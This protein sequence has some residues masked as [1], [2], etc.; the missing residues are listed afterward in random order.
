M[1]KFKAIL[2]LLLVAALFCML[3]AACGTSESNSGDSSSA[4]TST[5]SNTPANNDDEDDQDADAGDGE[6]VNIVVAYLDVSGND[7]EE[8]DRLT[9]Y[10]NSI[11]EP[12]IGVHVSIYN[13]QM[14]DYGTQVPLMIAGNEQLDVVNVSPMGGTKLSGLLSNNSLLDVREELETYAAEAIAICGDTADVYRVGDAMYGLPTYRVNASNEYIILRKDILEA[15]DTLDMANNISTWSDV[16]ELFAA[17]YD[18]CT[19]NNVYVIGGQKSCINVQAFWH[20]DSLDDYTN[21]ENLGESANMITVGEDGKVY[22]RW[23]DPDLVN[24]MKRAVNWNNNGW[25][26]PDTVLG[27]DHT[28]NLYKQGVIFSYFNHTEIGVEVA[29]KLSS[30]YD[31]VCPMLAQGK[32]QTSNLSTFGVAVPITCEEPEAACK[33]INMLYTDSRIVT[34]FAWGVEGEDYELNDAGEAVTPANP[35][36][37]YKGQDYMI[38]NQMLVPPWEGQGGDFRQVADE[39]NKSLESSAYLGLML[40]TSDLDT[41]VASL[42]N[43]YNEFYPALCSGQYTDEYYEQYISKLYSVGLQDY[44]DAIQEQVDAFVASK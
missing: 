7:S 34:V 36:Y 29:R 23:E 40:D 14:G 24:F 22:C 43:V 9:D 10:V 21:L 13:G 33:F 26:Y 12:E 32:I 4:G 2:A 27:D 18:Y 39:Y 44:M 37:G 19:E 35:Q 20:S 15:T 11:T 25:V 41:L 16:E 31:V 30:G 38:G 42:T 17:V 1:K 28:D 8:W 3:F 6:I 5:G